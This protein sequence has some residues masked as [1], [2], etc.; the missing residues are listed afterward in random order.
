MIKNLMSNKFHACNVP[1]K[2]KLR[3]RKAMKELNLW[4]REQRV[5]EAPVTSLGGLLHT[6]GGQVAR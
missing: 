1:R 2:D 6:F 3:S 5:L 4:R